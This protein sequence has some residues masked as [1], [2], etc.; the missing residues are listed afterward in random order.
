M[1]PDRDPCKYVNLL[2]DNGYIMEPP[3]QLIIHK[4]KN[5]IRSSHK[6]QKSIVFTLKLFM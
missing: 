5:K 1:S 4:D 6:K 3:E 2:Y